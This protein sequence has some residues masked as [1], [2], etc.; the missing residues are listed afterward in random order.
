MLGALHWVA[1]PHIFTMLLVVVLL[2]LLDRRDRVPFWWLVPLFGLWANLHGGFSFGL[3]L[4][5]LYLVGELIETKWAP[6]GERPPWR[7]MGYVLALPAA[8]LGACI[9]PHGLSLFRHVF[10]FFGHSLILDQTQE[11]MSP[12]FHVLAGKAFMA[13]VLLIV[14]GLALYPRRPT[15]TQLLVLLATLA[16]SLVSARNVE[17]F[18]LTAVPLMALHFDPEWRGLRI[19]PRVRAAFAEELKARNRGMPALVVTPLLLAL[20][21]AQGRFGPVQVVQNRFDPAV[22][23]VAAVR[24]AR[25]AGVEG[26]LYSEFTWNGYIL[27]AWPEQRVFIDGGTDHYGEAISAEEIRLWNLEPGW[28]EIVRRRDFSTMVLPVRSRLAYEIGRTPGWRRWYGDSTAVI[29]RRE[30]GE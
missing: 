20:A 29:Y 16:F 10:G 19:L 30:S 2:E 8:L 13:V 25:E 11:F 14:A 27:L 6:E 23:P 4:I 9:N 3:V 21:V 28:D 18:G 22:F 26:R 17:L 15:A 5:A 12:D 1:R 7:V 24:Q